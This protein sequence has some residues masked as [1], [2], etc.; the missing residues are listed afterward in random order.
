MKVKQ[1]EVKF[2]ISRRILW[3][4]QNAYPLPQVSS[5]RPIEII[6]R[7]GRILVEYGRRAGATLVA[8]VAGL[9]ILACLG[10]A[11]PAVLTVLFVVAASGVLVW[12][13]V[14][15]VRTLR[16]GRLYVLR[17]STAG[18]Q[19]SAVISRD[20]A[21]IEDLTHRVADAIDNPATEYTTYVENLEIIGGD[22]YAGDHVVGDKY[23]DDR[24]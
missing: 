2:H 19:H 11:V 15:L 16:R 12:H 14:D 7:R 10:K 22:K 6:P 4:D 21:L 20:R 13:T 5:V 3:V 9:I 24:L 17:V 8:G 18:N 23:S 1:E